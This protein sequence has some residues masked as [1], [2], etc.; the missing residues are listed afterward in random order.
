MGDGPGWYRDPSGAYSY[1]YW[2]GA[3]WTSRVSSGGATGNDPNPMDP[4]V[5]ATPPA[6]GTAAPVQV[7]P[8]QPTVQVTQSRGGSG[9]GTVVAIVLGVIA[10]I[11]VIALL[12]NAASEE[13]PTPDIDITVT[14]QAPAEPP[15]DS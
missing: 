10:I 1:R 12:A 13:E 5:A 11:V 9:A 14:T 15:A 4:G 3:Q 7:V 8:P 2:D 6:P